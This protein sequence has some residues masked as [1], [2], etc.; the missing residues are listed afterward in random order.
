MPK[1]SLRLKEKSSNEAPTKKITTQWQCL[2]LGAKPEDVEV[3][4]FIPRECDLCL[5]KMAAFDLDGTLINTASGLKFPKDRGDWKWWSDEVPRKLNFIKSDHQIVIFSNQGGTKVSADVKISDL[6]FKMERIMHMLGFEFP[7]FFSLKRT[8]HRKPLT[9]MWEIYVDFIK[10]PVD[11]TLSFYVGDAAGRPANWAPGK[12]KDFSCSD[13]KFSKNI[14]IGFFTPEEYFLNQLPFPFDWADIKHPSVHIDKSVTESDVHK[15]ISHLPNQEIIL[16]CGSPAS[17]KSSFAKTFLTK[18]T[19]ISRDILGGSTAK[20]CL[21][22]AK[23]SLKAGKS[24][25]IDNTNPDKAS[26]KVF[27][28]LARECKVPI[29]AFVMSTPRELCEHLNHVR[30]IVGDPYGTNRSVVPLVAFNTFKSRYLL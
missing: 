1:R 27:V 5:S 10:L 11:K 19:I 23:L 12:K 20:S 15:L 13:R 3:L 16:M 18:Y 6:K 7:V 4:F 29:R 22:A 26:R 30:I 8:A 24:V 9:R 17:G 2:P 14:D 28:D 25:V 21:K